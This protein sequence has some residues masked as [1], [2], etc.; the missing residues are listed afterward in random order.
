MNKHTPGPWTLDDEL[1]IYGD[2]KEIARSVLGIGTWEENFANAN[3]MA[4]APELLEV[5]KMV[6][7]HYSASL[8]YQPPYVNAA[9]AAIVKTE[10][11]S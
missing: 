9:K 8:D 7:N 3:L 10:G 6:V 11:K 1:E 5:A 4:A 2:G